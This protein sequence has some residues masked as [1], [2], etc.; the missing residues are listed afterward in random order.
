[1]ELDGVGWSW[2]VGV[3]ECWSV[4]IGKVLVHGLSQHYWLIG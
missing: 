1:M 2:S 3:L 4:E